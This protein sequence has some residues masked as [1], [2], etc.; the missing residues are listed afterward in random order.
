MTQSPEQVILSPTRLA[1]VLH[2]VENGGTAKYTDVCRTLGIKTGSM[3]VH[4][5]RLEDA[6]I[7]R[8]RKRF[9]DRRPV[10]S[11]AL[12]DAGRRALAGHKAVMAAVEPEEM[13]A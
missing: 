3:S 2:L 7:I 12:T 8:I 5:R 11:F 9:E 13:H 6:G 4:A 10:T 1:V